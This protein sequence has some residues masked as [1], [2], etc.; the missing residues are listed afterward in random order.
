MLSSGEIRKKFLDFFASK[1]HKIVPSSPIVNKNDPT[2]MFTNSGM[3]QFKDFF[4]GNQVPPYKRVADTQKCLRVSGKHNDLEDVGF[5]GT[6]HTMFEMLGN[7]SFGDYFKK[8]AVEWSWELLTEVYGLPKDRL[9]ATVFGGDANEKL[10]R[11]QEAFDLWRQYLPENH[12]LDGN[13]KDNFW[14]MGE[15]GPCGPCSEIHIDLRSDEERKL[16]PGENLVNLDHPRVIE[17]WNNVF[18][19]FNRKADASLEPLPAR[20]VDTGMGFE[21]LC[22]CLQDKFY[23][24]DTDVF[25]P[26]ID[27]VSKVSGK[28]YLSSYDREAK[29]DIAM[30]VVADHIRTVSFAIADG[31]MPSNTGAGYVIRRILRRAVRYYY[32]FLDIREPLMYKMVKLLSEE[33]K[34]I[35]PELIAQNDF[36]TRVVQEEEKSFLRTLEGGLKRIENLDISTGKIDGNTAF[37]L[38][39]TFGFPFDLTRLIAQEKNLEVDSEGFDIALSE[40]RKRSQA[41]AVRQVGD[42]EQLTDDVAVEFVG[43]DQIEVR[44]S[45]VVKYRTVHQKGKDNFH[46]VLNRT[47]FYA[48]SGGQL[49]DTGIMNFGGEEIQVLDTRK[50]NDLIIHVVNKLP[51]YISDE[52]VLARID[53]ERRGHI[54]LNHSATHL[55]HAALRE[56]LGTHVTQK[57]SMVSDEYLR[58][59]FA[60]FQKM[61]EEELLKVEQRVNEKI[62]EDISLEEVRKMP[63][64][65]AKASGAMML[66]GEKYGEYVRMITFDASYSRELCGGCHVTS[67]GKIGMFKITSEAAIAAGVRRIEAVTGFFAET[68]FHDAVS[69]LNASKQLLKSPKGLPESIRSLMDENKLLQKEIEH[70]I[71]EQA[72]GLKV[73]LLAEVKKSGDL[74]YLIKQIAISDSKAIKNLGYAIQKEIQGS[75]FILLANESQGKPMLTLILD[76]TAVKKYGLDAGKIIRQLSTHIKGGGGGQAFFASAGGTEISGISPALNDALNLIPK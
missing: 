69:E 21:R 29:S 2:L 60:H 63:I 31:E 62:R 71:Q 6:H 43:Y 55:L 16:I 34:D 10:D 39:D 24:Y 52:T 53:A 26:L 74:S 56:V 5:D 67:T 73:G 38:Y 49:G 30:R 66:F 8:E 3:V 61:T 25:S 64:D 17:I 47:P 23:T 20:H 1:G 50:E 42:W 32:S 11:D 76:E 19:Q 37:E 14:E 58:F 65:E 28:K 40:Q 36:V 45:R 68:Y 15:Q 13:K 51:K 33:F 46:I 7:W 57:G 54:I 35:F 12:I 22:M 48:E 72:N 44:N 59:D 70:L 75:S 4:L 27:F 18:M 41:D 9:Y